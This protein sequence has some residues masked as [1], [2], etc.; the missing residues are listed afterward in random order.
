ME[1]KKR[2]DVHRP[3]YFSARLCKSRAFFATFA[4][5]WLHWM[6][7]SNVLPP[8]SVALVQYDRCI[9]SESTKIVM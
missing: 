7:D 6:L 2:A 5:C 9:V 8:D 3:A 4:V 1:N